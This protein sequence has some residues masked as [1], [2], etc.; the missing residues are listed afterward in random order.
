MR[1]VADVGE[2][3]VVPLHNEVPHHEDAYESGG[4]TSSILDLGT[5]WR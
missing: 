1:A 3:K 4:I 5:N 2:A